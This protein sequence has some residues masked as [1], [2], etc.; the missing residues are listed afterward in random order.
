[1]G[2]SFY[3][4]RWIGVAVWRWLHRWTLAVYVLG[5]V[6]TLGSGTDARSAWLIGLLAAT[7]TPIVFA[8]SYRLLPAP[9]RARRTALP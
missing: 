7:A 6:H 9:A 2:L 4:R 5:I 1:V 3:V 8:G